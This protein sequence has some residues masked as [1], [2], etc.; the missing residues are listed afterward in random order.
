MLAPVR[1]T[2]SSEIARTFTYPTFGRAQPHRI[3]G[4]KRQKEAGVVENSP[5]WKTQSIAAAF[6]VEQLAMR[7]Q[8]LANEA[9]LHQH[10]SLHPPH[11]RRIA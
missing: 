6:S 11:G 3:K 1:G 7:Q 5:E 8:A 9:P 2:V 10:G 4:R